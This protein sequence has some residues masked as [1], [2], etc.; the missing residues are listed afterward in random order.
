MAILKLTSSAARILSPRAIV[1]N[2][3]ARRRNKQQKVPTRRPLARFARYDKV[4]PVAVLVLSSPKLILFPRNA[5]TVLWGD[6]AP[7]NPP[8]QVAWR[9]AGGDGNPKPR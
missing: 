4:V 9:R 8:R 3:G 5:P 2:N 7:T 6:I 1:R